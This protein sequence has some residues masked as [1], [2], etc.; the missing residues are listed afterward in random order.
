MSWP[1]VNL[2]EILSFK[3][4]SALKKEDRRSGNYPVMGSNGRVGSHDEGSTTGATIVIG[5]KG[6]IGE[7]VYSETSCW[8][9]DTTYFV[10]SKETVQDLRWLYWQLKGAGLNNMNRGAAIPGLNREDAYA[11]SVLLPPLPEQR[12]IAA[13]LDQADELRTKRRR[14]LTLLDEL[15]DSLF[16]SEFGTVG[17]ANRAD[18]HK[19]GE[20]AVIKSGSTPDRSRSDFYGGS[21]PWVKTGEVKG[22]L[23]MATEESVTETGRLAARLQLFPEG[24]IVIAMYGQGKTRG[25]SAPLG[26]GATVNQA[27]AVILPNARFETSF[28]THQLRLAYDRLREK[29]RGGNQANLNLGLVG[30][31]DILLPSIDAQ[32]VFGMRLAKLNRLRV[33]MRSQVREIDELFASLQHRAFRGE[34]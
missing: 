26:I 8:P 21:I 10:S 11:V 32:A 20:V 5:R 2:G 14:A 24:A 23:I 4:G 33:A 7:I 17:T 9:I 15:A 12:R 30:D 34:L 3:Y 27:C 25:Q 28:M 29:A 18:L 16:L 19:L 6:S 31:L 22:Q 13:I 1:T